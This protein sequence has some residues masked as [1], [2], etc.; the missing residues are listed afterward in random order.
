MC[1]GIKR[2][3]PARI[4][5]N[6]GLFLS[7]VGFYR[8]QAKFA[9]VMLL[10]MSVCPK[11]GGEYLA[12]YPSGQLPPRQVHPL[13]RYT[14]PRHVH[15]LGRY[16]HLGRYPPGQ[17]HPRQVHPLGRYTPLG[18]Y[19]PRACTPPTMHAGIRSTSGRYASHWNAFLLCKVFTLVIHMC[20]FRTL[21]PVLYLITVMTIP[22][23]IGILWNC[24]P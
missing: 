20:C 5:V 4:S 11:G 16:T 6:S 17:V 10:H 18:R 3:H 1:Q 24:A 15:P 21:Y 2:Q 19:L 12:R 23:Y 14:S 22:L 8:P 9:K 13:G 7:I